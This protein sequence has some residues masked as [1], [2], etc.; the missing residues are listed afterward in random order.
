M[1][2]FS[3]RLENR[4]FG[5]DCDHLIVPSTSE[6]VGIQRKSQTRKEF[7]FL[8][9]SPKRK[10]RNNFEKVQRREAN[11]PTSV[12]SVTTGRS[13]RSPSRSLKKVEP[14]RN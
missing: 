1:R 11:K 5:I 9:A 10:R 13:N 8:G 14:A 2:S 7:E 3:V 12:Q 4:R 6:R